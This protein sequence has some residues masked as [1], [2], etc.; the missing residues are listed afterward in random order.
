MPTLAG[1]SAEFIYQALID[2]KS[3]KRAATIMDRLAKGYSNEQLRH[4]AEVLGAANDAVK[5]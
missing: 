3:G 4:I 1:R 2:F 5:K